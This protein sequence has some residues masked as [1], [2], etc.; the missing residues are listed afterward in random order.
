MHVG[1]LVQV[2]GALAQA[3]KLDQLKAAAQKVPRAS[4]LSH[5]LLDIDAAHT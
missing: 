1:W 4:Q 2:D 5:C 3:A